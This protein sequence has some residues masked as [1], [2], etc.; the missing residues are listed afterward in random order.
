MALDSSFFVSEAVHEQVVKLG[1]EEHILHFRELPA[2]EFLKMQAHL[3]SVDED[4]RDA[5][6]CKIV[7]K[8]VCNPDGKLAMTEDQALNLRTD[9]LNALFTAILKVNGRGDEDEGAGKL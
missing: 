8:S 2:V 5:A 7:A 4:V 3:Q 1:N 9:A 6:M